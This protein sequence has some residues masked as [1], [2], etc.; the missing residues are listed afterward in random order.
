MGGGESLLCKSKW[1]HFHRHLGAVNWQPSSMDFL[2][3]SS[4]SRFQQHYL[5]QQFTIPFCLSCSSRP[6]ESITFLAKQKH[7][8]KSSNIWAHYNLSPA[9]AFDRCHEFTSPMWDLIQHWQRHGLAQGISDP[10]QS[11]TYFCFG[12]WH[13]HKEIISSQ[14]L[15]VTKLWTD[16]GKSS[17]WLSVNIQDPEIPSAVFWPSLRCY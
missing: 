8:H 7:P 12:I 9:R 5:Q 17:L 14:L 13:P 10:Q 4:G 3:N 15:S 6:R 11:Y 2:V 16:N 1:N